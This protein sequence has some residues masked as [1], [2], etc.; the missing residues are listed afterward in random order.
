MSYSYRGRERFGRVIKTDLSTSIESMIP[1][2]SLTREE[3]LEGSPVE[4]LGDTF[5]MA[6]TADN[7]YGIVGELESEPKLSF[8]VVIRREETSAV[9]RCL[10]DSGITKGDKL[11]IEGGV[12]VL[13]VEGSLIVGQAESDA[14]VKT[15]HDAVSIQFN[16]INSVVPTA[17]T[18]GGD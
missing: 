4:N 15:T 12:F 8:P 6:S 10:K 13:A 5:G 1:D 11:T 14:V 9:G 16:V 18:G 17:D 7:F 2:G 3:I